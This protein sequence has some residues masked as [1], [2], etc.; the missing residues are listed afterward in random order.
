[1]AVMTTEDIR[2]EIIMVTEVIVTDM[3]EAIEIPRTETE[4][5]IEEATETI[6]DIVRTDYILVL[7]LK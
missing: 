4:D 7:Y 2:R 3:T 5:Q 1:M 6:E